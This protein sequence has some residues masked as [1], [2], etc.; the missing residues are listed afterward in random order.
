VGSFAF[1][2]RGKV[3]TARFK[4]VLLDAAEGEASL[5]AERCSKRL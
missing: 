2:G 4:P 3:L 1:A 5:A